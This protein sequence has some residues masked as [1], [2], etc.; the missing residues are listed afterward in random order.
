[1]KLTQKQLANLVGVSQQQ[2]Q[3]IETG[4]QTVR[5]ELA[6]LLS[7]TLQAP[8]DQL[9][10]GAKKTLT[11]LRKKGRA[12]DLEDE[13]VTDGLAEAGIDADPRVWTIKY[14][15]RNGLSGFFEVAGTE[16]KR[17]WRAVQGFGLDQTP[18][19]VFDTQSDR[20]AINRNHLLFCQFLFDPPH[21]ATGKESRRSRGV[22]VYMC[23]SAEPLEFDVDADIFELGD[24]DSSEYGTQLQNLFFT[25]DCY[26][27]ADEIVCFTD[28]DG[29]TAFFRAADIAMLLV[30]LRDVEPALFHNEIDALD[31][32]DS[33]EN[34]GEADADFEDY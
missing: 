28:V 11:S 26:C 10:P 29:E 2:V 27:E 19:M 32:P 21:S 7:S 3:R 6:I 5:L 24:D 4:V 15:L 30:P 33:D 18:F 13:K 34:E 17:L 22:E 14:L 16:K 8:L 31:E 9:F 25:F 12:P 23:Q 20:I 1:M